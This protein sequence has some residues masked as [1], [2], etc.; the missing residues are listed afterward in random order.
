MPIIVVATLG[1]IIA[2]NAVQT[3]SSILDCVI[4]ASHNAMAAKF[5][6]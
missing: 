1:G 2:K 5:H 4:V 3:S 6:W